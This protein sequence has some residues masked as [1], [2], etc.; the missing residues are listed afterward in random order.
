MARVCMVAYAPYPVDTRIR[1][2]AEA[3]ADRGDEVDVICLKEKGREN[4]QTFNGVRSFQLPIDK[5]RGSSA[6]RYLLQYTLFFLA[7]SLRLTSRHLKQRYQVIQVHTMPDFMVF[8][9]LVP[10]LLGAKVVLDVHDLMPELYQT[11]FSLRESHWL[12]RFITWMERR[13]I[14]FAHRAIAVH[15]PHLDALSNHGNS[16]EKFIILPNLPDPRIFSKQAR[17]DT[18]H[19]GKFVLIYHGTV[20]RRH[21]LRVALRAVSQVKKEIKGL[22]FW[23]FGVGE[24]LPHLNSLARELDLSDCVYISEGM[25][26]IDELIPVILEADVGIVPI[27]NDEFTKYMLPTKLL[28]YVALGIPVICSRTETIEAYF[29]DSM[30]QYVESGNADDLAQ[31]VLDLYRNPSKRKTLASNADRFNRDYNWEVVKQR[32]Y[33]LIDDLSRQD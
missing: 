19:D 29:D 20:T 12:I 8:V 10:R 26:P 15:R 22:R 32:Y 13:S 14:G 25:I 28:E 31:K 21:G 7:A 1:R 3:L 23:I 6:A 2:E 5:Y 18:Q 16:A 33:Q 27:L 30:I 9:A 17:S 11:K 4:T 24:D